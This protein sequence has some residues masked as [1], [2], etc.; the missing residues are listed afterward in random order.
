[1]DAA[2]DQALGDVHRADPERFLLLVREHAFVQGRLRERQVIQ[3]VEAELDVVRVEY[4]QFTGALQI[5]AKGFHIGPRAQ[6]H[7]E[8]PPEGMHTADGLPARVDGIVHPSEL[9]VGFD[10]TGAG[11]EG[12]ERLA[13]TDRAGAG[14][15]A[16]VRGGE[17]LVQVHVHNVDPDAAHVGIAHDCIQVRAVA[18][19]EAAA[20]VH[21]FGDF[22]DVGLEQAKRVRVRDHDPGAVVVHQGGHILNGQ[23]AGG[24]DRNFHRREAAQGGCSR[25]GAVRGIGNEHLG[26]L[27]A[28]RPVPRLNEHD[29]GEFAVRTGGRLEATRLKAG[30]GAQHLLG[31]I[32]HPQGTLRI[33]GGKQRMRTGKAG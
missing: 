6:H 32:E 4:G 16:A 10:Q 27:V 19:D 29:A 22:L 24:A 14:A 17:R 2:V 7:A 20:G 11:Q 15:A 12:H 30:H 9:A 1:M 31:F 8:L 3:I 18:V 23:D 13:H 25:V 5:R 21:E 33:F 26:A 28:L